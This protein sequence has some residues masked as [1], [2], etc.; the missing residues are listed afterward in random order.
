MYKGGRNFGGNMQNLMRQAQKMQAEMQTKMEK[1]DDEL[2]KTNINTVV[3]GGL[4]EIVM[5][6]N[7]KVVDIKLKKEAVDPD[8]IEMLQD[9]IIVGMNEA[10]E[11]SDDLQKKLKG[12]ISGGMF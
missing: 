4:L 9:L 10:L 11:K 7:K 1:A 12:G 5:N 3:G 2:E 8:D 6:G